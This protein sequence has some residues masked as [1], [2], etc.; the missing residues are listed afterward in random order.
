MLGDSSLGAAPAS[1]RAAPARPRAAPASPRA[2]P[3]QEDASYEQPDFEPAIA[4]APNESFEKPDFQAAM[5]AATH[6]EHYI[7]GLQQQQEADANAGDGLPLGA[8]AFFEGGAA[9]PRRRA[10][11]STRAVDGADGHSRAHRR[12]ADA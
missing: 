11:A 1:P 5:C 10:D 6:M 4:A 8:G 12:R 9:E 2:A 7:T 3:A